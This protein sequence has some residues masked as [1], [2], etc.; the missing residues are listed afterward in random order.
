MWKLGN[1]RLQSK[2]EKKLWKVDLHLHTVFSS[3]G[4]IT[5]EQAAK[6]GTREGFDCLA[7]T[8]HNEISGAIKLAE[9]STIKIIIGEEIR[10][11][12]GDI[13]G[14]FLNERIPPYL[15]MKETI[16]MI[17][18][19][20]GI[21]YLPHPFKLDENVIMDNIGC[22]DIV[23]IYNSSYKRSRKSNFVLE[24]AHKYE[25]IVASGSDAHTA[26]E[27]G[28][29]YIEMESFEG[30]DDFLPKLRDGYLHV[31]FTP[32]WYKALTNSYVRKSL[33]FL[34]I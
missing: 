32:F 22:I 5:I 12:D 1:N 9:I 27:I 24:L 16:E 30:R 26:F 14:L 3:D 6:I 18:S 10:T 4:L 7:V 28:N 11:K 17:K 20:D 15:S 8:D 2:A 25:K 31:R 34:R 13:I 23:E 19:Q 33:R 21:V 29:S